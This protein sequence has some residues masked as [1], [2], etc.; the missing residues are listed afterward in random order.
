MLGRALYFIAFAMVFGCLCLPAT[1]R[2]E[3]MDEPPPGITIMADESLTT[4]LT[5]I[6]RAYAAEYQVPVSAQFGP[7]NLQIREVEEGGE[8]NVIIAA[9]SIWIRQLEVKGL[10]DVYSRTPVARNALVLAAPTINTQQITLTPE[11]T[12]AALLHEG[13]A[14]EELTLALGDPEFTAEGTYALDALSRLKLDG[15]LEPYFVF[16]RDVQELV[17]SLDTPNSYGMLYQTEALLYPGLRVVENIAPQAHTPIVYE[18]VTVAGE[19]M[20]GGRQFVDYLTSDKARTIF[21]RYGF[22]PAL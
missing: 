20:S 7:T 5:L 11:L 10:I 6:A 16:F 1:A 15:E 18:A 3:G 2:A 17:A 9:K 12:A 22:L 21:T 19:N 8:A 14:P 4:A 13:D